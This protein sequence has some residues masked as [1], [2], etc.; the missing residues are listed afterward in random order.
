MVLRMQSVGLKLSPT[1]SRCGRGEL[2]ATEF[3]RKTLLP[4]TASGS[5]HHRRPGFIDASATNLLTFGPQSRLP[6]FS[7]KDPSGPCHAELALA[8]DPL[9]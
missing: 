4:L 7:S 5:A 6:R 8:D 2:R 9:G 1:A 3:M